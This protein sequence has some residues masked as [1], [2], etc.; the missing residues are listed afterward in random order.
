MAKGWSRET[1]RYF[2]VAYREA[3]TLA[4]QL[5]T[6][7]KLFA[8]LTHDSDPKTKPGFYG[9]NAVKVFLGEDYKKADGLTPDMLA[10]YTPTWRQELDVMAE[11]GVLPHLIVVLGSQ[12]WEVMWRTLHP[13]HG[14]AS[15]HFTVDDYRTCGG[16]GSPCYHHA[17]LITLAIGERKHSLLLV[18][19][20]HPAA[21]GNRHAKW[22]LEQEAFRELVQLG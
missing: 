15:E 17:N 9:T 8:G 20:T 4:R 5:S 3:D 21:Q 16:R 13:T 10:Q 1:H 12:I 2:N 7:S 19:L 6:D 14:M 11:H 18:R 22:L